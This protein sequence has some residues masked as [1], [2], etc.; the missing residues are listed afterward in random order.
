MDRFPA[1]SSTVHGDGSHKRQDFNASVPEDV[2]TTVTG[3]KARAVSLTLKGLLPPV[4]AFNVVGLR[5]TSPSP[6]PLPKGERES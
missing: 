2:V 6:C 4:P 3:H 5:G 1:A